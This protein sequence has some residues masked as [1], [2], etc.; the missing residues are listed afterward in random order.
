MIYNEKEKIYFKK[1]DKPIAIKK[2]EDLFE[3]LKK[4]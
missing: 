1:E 4:D 3:N 2:V